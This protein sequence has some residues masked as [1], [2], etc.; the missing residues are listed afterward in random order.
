[1]LLM[2]KYFNAKV[3]LIEILWAWPTFRFNDE[4]EKL[5]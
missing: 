3:S 1:M 4:S 2:L 5:L